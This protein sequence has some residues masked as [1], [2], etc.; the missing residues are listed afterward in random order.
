MQINSLNVAASQQL[1]VT[2]TLESSRL[3]VHG[4]P[5][6]SGMLVTAAP[7]TDMLAR[8]GAHR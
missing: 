3:A 2:S 6:L 4:A 7:V 1:D 8:V 5:S